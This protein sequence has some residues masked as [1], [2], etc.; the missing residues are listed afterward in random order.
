M[1]K[2]VKDMMTKMYRQMFAETDS[3]LLVDIRGVG[4]NDNNALRNDLA[5]KDIRITVVR[6]NLARSAF[7]DLK[8]APLNELIDGPSALVTGGQSVVNVARELIDWA[9]K[10]RNL[11]I[12]GAVMDG[13]VF[14]PERIDELSK[15]PTREEALAQVVQL[16]ISPAAA[17]VATVAGPGS[18]VVNIVDE[19]AR[20]LEAGETIAA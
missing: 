2:P 9:R 1:S 5:K 11:E 12:K 4:S 17:L 18:Q 13:V 6:N 10:L 15:L 20:K 7:A 8:L 3:A 16:V 19:L 14:G